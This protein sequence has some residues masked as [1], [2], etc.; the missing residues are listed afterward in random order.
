M[1]KWPRAYEM[2]MDTISHQEKV[3]QNPSEVPLHES[4]S[5]I[6]NFVEDM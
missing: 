4:K 3:N 5:E 1:Y 6:T 2:M